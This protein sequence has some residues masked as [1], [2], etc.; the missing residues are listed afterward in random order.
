M[1][2]KNAINLP[3]RLA[4]GMPIRAFGTF[5]FKVSDDRF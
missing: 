2:T 5:S 1:G 3:F 4:C